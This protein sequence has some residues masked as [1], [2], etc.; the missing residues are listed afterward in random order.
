MQ[1]DIECRKRQEH[2]AG[3]MLKYFVDGDTYYGNDAQIAQC[4]V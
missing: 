4:A 2:A 1:N 3:F